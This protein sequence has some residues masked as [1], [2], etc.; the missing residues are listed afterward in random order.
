MVLQEDG[1]MHGRLCVHDAL[2]D[3]CARQPCRRRRHDASWR[4]AKRPT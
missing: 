2:A 1:S 4:A 3:A